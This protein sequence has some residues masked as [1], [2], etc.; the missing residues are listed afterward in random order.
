MKLNKQIAKL[1][2]QI[3][4]HRNIETGW[5]NKIPKPI[6]LNIS[7]SLTNTPATK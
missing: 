1:V 3:I 7:S 2:K 4:N 6:H 5:V